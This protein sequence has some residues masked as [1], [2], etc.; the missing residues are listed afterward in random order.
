MALRS[1]ESQKVFQPEL[2]IVLFCVVCV[3]KCVLYCTVLLPPGVNP[4]AVNK[5]ITIKNV[6]ATHTNHTASRPEC[7]PRC[8]NDDKLP[9]FLQTHGFI[10]QLGDYQLI[11][12]YSPRSKL[13]GDQNAPFCEFLKRKTMN[14]EGHGSGRGQPQGIIPVKGQQEELTPARLGPPTFELYVNQLHTGL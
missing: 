6:R 13:L 10:D 1:F 8:A 7:L 14:N 9:C 4:I 3:C 2:L 11:R 12:K 5:Y